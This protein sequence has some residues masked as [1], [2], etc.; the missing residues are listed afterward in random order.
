MGLAHLY[1]YTR[2]TSHF[3]RFQSDTV[4]KILQVANVTVRYDRSDEVV[5]LTV[6]DYAFR[7]MCNGRARGPDGDIDFY[8]LRYLGL[9]RKNTDARV[10]AH[11]AQRDDV[12]VAHRLSYPAQFV[13]FAPM[14][15]PSLYVRL[16]RERSRFQLPRHR[17]PLLRHVHE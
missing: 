16:R 3:E 1:S 11:R 10:E 9:V 12:L 6:V 4:C 14:R 17:R 15:M 7:A 8:R 2:H 13:R 5:E